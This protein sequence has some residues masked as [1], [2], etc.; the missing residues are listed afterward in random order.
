MRNTYSLKNNYE[1]RRLYQRGKSAV[2]SYLAVYFRQS[3]NPANR[4]GITVST[5][6]GNAVIRNRVRRR[7]KEAYRLNEE[8]FISPVDLVIVSRVRC[9]S[10]SFH[11]IEKALLALSSKLGLLK[12]ADNEKNIDF[13]D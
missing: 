10:A 6:V 2:N 13:N 8:K 5:K 3:R 11:Q 12:G 7:I 1:F 4:L 9:S